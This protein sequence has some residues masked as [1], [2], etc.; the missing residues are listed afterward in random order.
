[1]LQA[2]RK[3]TNADGL[4]RRNWY[5]HLIYAPGFYTGYGAKTL[6]GI[7]EGIEEKRY[8]E[9]EKEIIRAAQAVQDYAAVIDSAA[10]DL[11][12]AGH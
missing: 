2:E 1:L 12:K 7:R 11:E 4:P 3:L 5:K 6:P 8:Q 9:A 10:G